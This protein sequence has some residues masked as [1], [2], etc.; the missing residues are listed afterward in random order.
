MVWEQETSRP[1]AAGLE[2][3]RGAEIGHTVVETPLC[4]LW[5]LSPTQFLLLAE[6]E[7]PGAT[8][9]AGP[10]SPTREALVCSR[11]FCLFVFP[12]DL[13]NGTKIQHELKKKKKKKLTETTQKTNKKW[14]QASFPLDL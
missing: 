4:P 10:M 12:I 3:L 1:Q 9:S 7:H 8:G 13:E 6:V 5:G 2:A 14:S 11:C